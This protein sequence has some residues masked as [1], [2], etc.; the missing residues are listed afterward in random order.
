MKFK[1]QI[2]QIVLKAEYY[3]IKQKSKSEILEYRRPFIYI[4]YKECEFKPR[5]LWVMR[6]RT[7]YNDNWVF[8]V[9]SCVSI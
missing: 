9:F 4:Y 6:G 1:E 5:K 7:F 3:Q 2:L 8:R